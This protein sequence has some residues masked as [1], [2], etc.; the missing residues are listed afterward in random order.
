MTF[1]FFSSLKGD[2][3]TVFVEYVVILT[4]VS[5][6]AS[7]ALISLGVPLLNL[8]SYQQTVLSLPFP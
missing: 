7:V 4:V 6:G 8:F 3:G 5:L 1:R 2:Q